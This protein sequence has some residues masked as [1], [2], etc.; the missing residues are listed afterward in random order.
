MTG[1]VQVNGR[2]SLSW[3]EKFEMDVWYV[4]HGSLAVDLKILLK[5]FRKVLARTGINAPGG[6][7]VPEFLG[8]ERRVDPVPVPLERPVDVGSRWRKGE[9]HDKRRNI[10]G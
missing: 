1:W 9:N 10:A 4:D 5:T 3:D 2:N 6:R 8:N 7:S